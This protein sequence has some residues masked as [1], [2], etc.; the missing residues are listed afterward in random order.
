MTQDTTIFSGP[1]LSYYIVRFKTRITLFIQGRGEAPYFTGEEAITVLSFLCASTRS[2]ATALGLWMQ[3][4]DFISNVGKQVPLCDNETWFYLG[5]SYNKHHTHDGLES[6]SVQIV[7]RRT[8]EIFT[9]GHISNITL[10]RDVLPDTPYHVKFKTFCSRNMSEELIEFWDAVHLYHTLDEKERTQEAQRIC[11]VYID[12][13]SQK[14]LNLS[15]VVLKTLEN[16]TPGSLDYFDAIEEHVELDMEDSLPRFKIYLKTESDEM[17]RKKLSR[18][19]M[20]FSLPINKRMS[21]SPTAFT[22]TSPPPSIFSG[23]KSLPSFN[24]VSPPSSPKSTSPKSPVRRMFTRLRRE[25]YEDLDNVLSNPELTSNFHSFCSK[26]NSEELIDFYFQV[27]NYKKIQGHEQRVYGAMCIKNLFL[28]TSDDK[29]PSVT[30]QNKPKIEA[31][32]KLIEKLDKKINSG[33]SS[34]FD[35]ILSEVMKG[36]LEKHSRWSTQQKIEM[37]E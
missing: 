7:Y 6:E 33:R 5:P 13:N 11:S 14:P 4:N 9:E 18:L 21:I 31:S 17:L 28:N 27:V 16:N 26:E 30:N 15:S 8:K 34:L 20:S 19:S 23:P 2:K 22:S 29:S 25:S 32:K 36:L 1:L 35:D 37:R 3:S 12:Q 24:S 10:T